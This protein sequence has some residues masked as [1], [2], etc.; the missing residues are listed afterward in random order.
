MGRPD[1]IQDAAA[2]GDLRSIKAMVEDDPGVVNSMEGG[3]AGE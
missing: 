2:V 3:R 1:T